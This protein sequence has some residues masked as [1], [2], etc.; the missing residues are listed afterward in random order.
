MIERII[1]VMISAAHKI[2]D[3]PKKCKN[4]H[5]HNYKI[6]AIGDFTEEEAELIKEIIFEQDHTYLNEFLGRNATAE[7]EAKYLH[8]KIKKK[9]PGLRKISVWETPKCGVSYF[10]E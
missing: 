1:E 6:R 8:D 3:H 10:N 4:L 2:E 9:V 7:L 5:G